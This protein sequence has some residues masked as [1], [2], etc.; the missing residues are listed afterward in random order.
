MSILAFLAAAGATFLAGPQ[1]NLEPTDLEALGIELS[2]I[3]ME[4]ELG[5]PYPLF[6]FEIGLEEFLGCETR[7]AGLDVFNEQG[8]HIFG[9]SIAE[10][11]GIYRF[12]I[13]EQ[14]MAA[15][16][17]RITCDA[18]PDELNPSYIIELLDYRRAP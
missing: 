18:G 3:D 16:V 12:N 9:T 2:V 7:S 4:I 1:T 6:L 5:H 11:Y 13:L 10:E 15:A 8:Q 14:F 17:F